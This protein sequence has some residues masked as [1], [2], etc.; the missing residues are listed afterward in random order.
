VPGSRPT[1]ASG[2]GPPTVGPDGLVAFLGQGSSP[3]TRPVGLP[4]SVPGVESS[5]SRQSEGP[6]DVPTISSRPGDGFVPGTWP[7]GGATS[8]PTD[9]VPGNSGTGSTG[10]GTVLKPEGEVVVLAQ[11]LARDLAQL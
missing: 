3:G 1:D 2:P 6:G 10:S 7:V 4:T 8:L 5:G 11:D 9:N